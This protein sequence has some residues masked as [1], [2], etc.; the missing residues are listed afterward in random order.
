MDDQP[1]L[2]DQYRMASPWPLF[3]ALGLAISEVGVVLNI[4]PLS[5]G[6][7]LLLVGTTAGIVQEAGYTDRPW[8][9][10]GGLGA[11]LVAF[12]GVLVATQVSAVS[13]AAVTDTVTGAFSGP[14]ANAIVQRGL[15]VA[16]AGAIALVASRVAVVMEPRRDPGTA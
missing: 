14:N 12:G 6:G 7:L 16:F 3:V 9:V 10:L 5:V 13:V 4:L 11:V 1:G 8:G 2:S 15:S